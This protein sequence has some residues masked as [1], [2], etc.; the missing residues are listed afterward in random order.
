MN[1]LGGTSRVV[2]WWTGLTG[3]ARS[4]TKAISAFVV[5]Y[6]GAIVENQVQV[7]AD[8][9]LLPSSFL[10]VLGVGAVFVAAGVLSLLWEE[11]V[12]A[13]DREVQWRRETMAYA[14]STVEQHTTWFAARIADAG[15]VSGA[16]LA[17]ADYLAV[18]TGGTAAI[19]N[20]ISL[21][22]QLFESRYGASHL[23]E[24][25]I[26][27]EVTFMCR[28]YR[29]G[30][31]TIPA[32]ANRARRAPRSM[33][34]RIANPK[35]YERTVTAQIYKASHPRTWI[36]ADTSAAHDAYAELYEGQKERIKSCIVHP[37]FSPG[38]VLLGTLVVHC[39]RADFFTEG[40]RKFWIELLE[41]FSRAIALE[42]GVLD[43]LY[44]RG[45]AALLG[46][47]GTPPF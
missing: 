16:S 7:L 29:D 42:K 25:R 18:L 32:S 15:A 3:T 2:G 27:F 41:V 19:Q 8:G 33:S 45:G 6:F 20:I 39:N 22:Y 35:L 24:E 34:D 31:I 5:F 43:S 1:V 47:T 38:N 4:L 10:H 40:H 30:E 26:D 14:M 13:H 46:A 44:E 9:A 17:P 12:A 23:S 11:A 21:A 28:S 37:V 36:V